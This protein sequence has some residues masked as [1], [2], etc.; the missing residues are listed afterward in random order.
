MSACDCECLRVSAVSAICVLCV[1]CVSMYV[2]VCGGKVRPA[3]CHATVMCGGSHGSRMAVA[4]A[5]P[6]PYIVLMISQNP[7]TSE[8]V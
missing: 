4:R 8:H 6:M 2:F 5:L 3:N 7:D 1:V